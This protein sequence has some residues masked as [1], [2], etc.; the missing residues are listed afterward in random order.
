MVS[1]LIDLGSVFL[2]LQSSFVED[3]VGCLLDFTSQLSLCLCEPFFQ[4]L[5]IECTHVNFLIDSKV[6]AN[7]GA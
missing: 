6:I 7:H 2:V 5:E 3:S 1:V 4:A